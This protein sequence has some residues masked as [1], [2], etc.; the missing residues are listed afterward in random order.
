MF[1]GRLEKSKGVHLLKEIDDKLKLSGVNVDWLIIGKGPMDHFLKNQWEGKN[2]VVFRAAKTNNEIYEWISGQDVF[3][4]PTTF[5]GTPVSILEC[6]S[7][8]IVPL[9]SNLP[10][11]I[12]DIVSDNIGF[13][14]PVND[15]EGYVDVITKLNAD[16]KL[17]H[18]LQRSSWEKAISNYDIKLNA[19]NYF[20]VFFD[21]T[22]LKRKNTKQKSINLSRLDKHYLPNFL[23]RLIRRIL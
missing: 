19:D 5:E 20:K 15:I 10:G 8:G 6:I 12:R 4:F 23:V 14:L 17:L 3:V 2:N 22:R 21:Y 7:N 1:L 18:N 9:V 11:G 13:K 16:R